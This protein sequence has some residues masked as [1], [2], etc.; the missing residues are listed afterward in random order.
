MGLGK[1]S[2]ED[3]EVLGEDVHQ[4]TAD[5]AVAGH[6]AITREDLLL[7][8]EVVGAVGN[9]GSDLLEGSGVQEEVDTLPRGEFPLSVLLIDAGLA[10][11]E[12]GGL[13]F[14]V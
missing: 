8:P 4:A 2:A 12:V 14:L 5:S 10:A 7:H 11:A 3:G 13:E 6:D 9:E 1:R